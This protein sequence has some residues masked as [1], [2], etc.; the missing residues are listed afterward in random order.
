MEQAEE[1]QKIYLEDIA[2][3]LNLPIGVVSKI[4][5]TLKEKNFVTWKH[6]GIGEDGTYIQLTEKGMHSF[7]E[8]QEILKDFYKNVI[9]QFGTERFVS[10]LEQIIEFEEIIGAEISKKGQEH[11]R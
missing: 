3:G 7:T 5:R 8:Q 6:D 2:Q 10:F 1:N 4:V 9:E 11:E